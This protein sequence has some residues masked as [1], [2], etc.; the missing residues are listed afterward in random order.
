MARDLI[1]KK[2]GNGSFGDVFE[3]IDKTNATQVAIKM[4]HVESPHQIL[5]HEYEIYQ[6]IYKP[7]VGIPKIHY[8][9]CECDYKV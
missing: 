7:N 2:L 9:G 4:E 5:A 3:G 1:G 6:Q 8:F